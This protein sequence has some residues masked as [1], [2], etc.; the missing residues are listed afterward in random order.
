V[1][2]AGEGG[3]V[4]PLGICKVSDGAF[5]EVEAEHGADPRTMNL[6]RQKIKTPMK[7]PR[8]FER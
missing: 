4:A 1:E 2:V 5:G 3:R 6:T 7:R 8:F